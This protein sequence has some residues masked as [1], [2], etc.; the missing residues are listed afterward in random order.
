MDTNSTEAENAAKRRWKK[1][2]NEKTLE[3][4]RPV[5]T[6]KGESEAWRTATGHVSERARGIGQLR[7]ASADLA[8]EQCPQI[9]HSADTTAAC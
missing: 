9:G 1:C 3:D 2:K 7:G 8:A 4:A 6:A 5:R